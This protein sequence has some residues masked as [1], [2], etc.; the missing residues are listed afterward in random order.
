MS[1]IA[2]YVIWI[3]GAPRAASDAKVPVLDR[4][5]LYGDSVYEVLRTVGKRPLLLAAHL[6][7]LESSATGLYFALPPRPV[8]EDAVAETIA[9]VPADECYVRIIVTRGAGELDLDPMAASEE[10]RLIVLAKPLKLPDERLYR[11]GA[12]IQTV[13]QRRNAPGHVPPS[14]K[15]GNYLSSV[16]ALRAARARGAGVYEAL[17]CD[18]NGY[19]A[20]GASSNFFIVER[21]SPDDEP[22]VV[23]PPLEVGLLAGITRAQLL[24]LATTSGIAVREERFTPL[25]AQAAEEAFLTSSI[26]GPMPVTRLD[27]EPIGSGVPGP[28]TRR[29]MALY[30][31]HIARAGN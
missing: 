19:V 28:L 22:V 17:L 7:R 18:Q 8:I 1:A 2:S 15:S 26:R 5:F 30:A 4:G 23:T 20:E 14:V 6:D 11:E 3:D 12:A 9:A 13:S 16:L 10:P 21:K 25:R 24:W 27:G 29:L 31:A